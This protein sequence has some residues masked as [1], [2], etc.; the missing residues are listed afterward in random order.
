MIPEGTVGKRALGW[1]KDE[2]CHVGLLHFAYLL[3]ELLSFVWGVPLTL[4]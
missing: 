4:N 3:V 1:G 2:Y